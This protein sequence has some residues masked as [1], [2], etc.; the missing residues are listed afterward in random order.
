MKRKWTCLLKKSLCVYVLEKYPSGGFIFGRVKNNRLVRPDEKW[1]LF[2]SPWLGI[3][4]SW[5]KIY[6][7]S[8]RVKQAAIQQ[9]MDDSC[10]HESKTSEI[11]NLK[12]MQHLNVWLDGSTFESLDSE[13][14]WI[15]SKGSML[16]ILISIQHSKQTQAMEVQ[17]LLYFCTNRL[18]GQLRS[19]P[20]TSISSCNFNISSFQKLKQGSALNK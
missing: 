2:G 11:G 20:G 12:L 15:N 18:W 5:S 10:K 16:P 3:R 6:V 4:S 7:L 9:N 19:Q 13:F 14:R 1:A 17:T 8:S